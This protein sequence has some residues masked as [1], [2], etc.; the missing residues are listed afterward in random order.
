MRTALGTALDTARH[1]RSLTLYASGRDIAAQQG[2]IIAD[3]KFE[4]GLDAA[5]QPI[6]IDEVLTPDSSRSL[7]GAGVRPWP[8][9]AELRQAAIARTGLLRRRAQ[10]AGTAT[11]RHRDFPIPWCRPRASAIAKPTD[12][13]VGHEL[14]EER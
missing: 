7:A 12:S 14:E 4:F 9:P 8:E 13:L 1:E 11:H 3:T 5:G 10:V 2:I 6:L